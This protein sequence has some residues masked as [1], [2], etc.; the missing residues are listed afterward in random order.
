MSECKESL[1][2][3]MDGET[4]AF[5][6]RRLLQRLDEDAELGQTWR[7]YHLARSALK[8]ETLA[9]C[10][11]DLSAR[12][13]AVIE[14]E[15]AHQSVETP[16]VEGDS[17]R[18]AGFGGLRRTLA[19]MAVAASVTAIVIFGANNFSPSLGEQP[20]VAQT[21]GNVAPVMQ[22]P[23]SAD[24]VRTQLGS[25]PAAVRSAGSVTDSA[26]VIRLSQGLTDYIDQHRHLLSARQSRWHSSW[27]PEGYK[28][29]AHELL[30]HGEVM[31]F[32]NGSATVSVTVEP[33]GYQRSAEG[34]V[35]DDGLVA[36]GRR[37]GE[38]FVT[39]VGDVPLMVADRIAASVKLIR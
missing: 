3:L 20:V 33:V 29:V 2:A 23:Y 21:S 8:G 11:S 39:V 19:S 7:R 18:R 4:E 1:S 38:H 35:R 24:L 10:E 37:Q 16:R 27:V 9:Q 28:P 32:T 17:E 5:E 34:V 6:T 14:N 25:T 31:M 30:P 26:D 13:S 36:V 12:I 15:P 22:S